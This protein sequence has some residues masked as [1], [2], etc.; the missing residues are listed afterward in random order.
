MSTTLGFRAID[1][2]T[3]ASTQ[4]KG[5]RLEMGHLSSGGKSRQVRK[6]DSALGHAAGEM[7]AQNGCLRRRP[8]SDGPIRLLSEE[9]VGNAIFT[10]SGRGFIGRFYWTSSAE[11]KPQLRL[12]EIGSVRRSHCAVFRFQA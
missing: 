7:K 5:R 12:P 9:A 6:Q 11:A 4:G 8:R 2:N 1:H 3:A 10:M